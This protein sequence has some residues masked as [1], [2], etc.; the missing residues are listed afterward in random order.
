MDTGNCGQADLIMSNARK[1]EDAER[2]REKIK[3]EDGE[4]KKMM[5]LMNE[6][7]GM[8]RI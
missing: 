5:L 3:D 1:D 6:R 7:N 8:E 4:R 2:E